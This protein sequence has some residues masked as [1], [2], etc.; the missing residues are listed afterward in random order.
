MPKCDLFDKQKLAWIHHKLDVTWMW[1][2]GVWE[3][4]SE[5]NRIL[6]TTRIKRGTTQKDFEN[7]FKLKSLLKICYLIW[8]PAVLLWWIFTLWWQRFFKKIFCH[9]CLVLFNRK[10]MTENLILEEMSSSFD[11]P[12]VY[13]HF[14]SVSKKLWIVF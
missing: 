7:L 9:R 4:Y 14:T 11:S 10:K 6:K 1:L 8:W 12:K 5:Q 13:H 2:I 3:F